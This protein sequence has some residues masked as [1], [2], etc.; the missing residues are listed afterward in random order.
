[1][2]TKLESNHPVEVRR[3]GSSD[4]ELARR[5]VALNQST[6]DRPL[7]VSEGALLDFL[8]DSSSYLLVALHG[9]EI[10]GSLYGYALKHPHR[11]QPQFLLYGIDV[12]WE[13]RNHGI[14]TALVSSF[15][16]EARRA[17]AFEVW[18]LTSQ[19]NQAA[20]AMYQRCGFKRCGSDEAML[21]LAL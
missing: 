17:R 7:P 4:L 15:V 20:L 11:S 8:S 6:S 13:R 19:A 10:A 14:G 16:Q 9:G 1:V 18:V 3:A 21:E 2:Q 12:S 5:A